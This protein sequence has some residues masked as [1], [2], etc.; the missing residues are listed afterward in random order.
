[1]K[2]KL[3]EILPDEEIEER[4]LD[5][6]RKISHAGLHCYFFIFFC[7]SVQEKNDVIP[8]LDITHVLLSFLNKTTPYYPLF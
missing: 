8:L 7:L 2:V 3:E 6:K 4:G 1:L 5:Q